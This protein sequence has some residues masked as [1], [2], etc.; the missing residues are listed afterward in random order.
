M[1]QWGNSSCE[2]STN[3]ISWIL[4][5]GLQ[6]RLTPTYNWGKRRLREQFAGSELAFAPK[7]SDSRQ[8]ENELHIIVVPFAWRC[9]VGNQVLRLCPPENISF[10]EN[11]CDSDA[12]TL[13][14]L[15]TGVKNGGR[16]GV[17]H[18]RLH[19]HGGAG[20]CVCQM[21]MRLWKSGNQ[22]L[23]KLKGFKIRK[24]FQRLSRE[25]TVG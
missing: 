14:S 18:L 11:N 6:T 25:N 8:R 22:H 3:T 12:V 20:R 5:A 13:L 15:D 1:I 21:Q 10:S 24:W 16:V 9:Q 7:Q 17:Q 19:T 2:C 23:V 4:R